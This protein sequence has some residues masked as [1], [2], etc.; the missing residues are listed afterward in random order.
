MFG[1]GIRKI[2]SK[3]M[4]IHKDGIVIS[5]GKDVLA[6]IPDESIGDTALVIPRDSIAMVVK[7]KYNPKYVAIK[8]WNGNYLFQIPK[9]QDLYVSEGK[10]LLRGK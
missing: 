8:N 1:A 6:R 5:M 7:E 2:M 3:Y 4:S 10:E 9:R